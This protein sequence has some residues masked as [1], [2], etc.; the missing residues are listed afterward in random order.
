MIKSNVSLSQVKTHIAHLKE[1][2]V[3]VTLALGRNKFVKFMAKVQGVYPA[4]F[5]VKPFDDGFNGRTSYSYQEF[6]CGR[7]RVKGVEPT[8][9]QS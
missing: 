4:L 7:V 1:K 3:E 8:I 5:T 2:Q 9:S 6:M